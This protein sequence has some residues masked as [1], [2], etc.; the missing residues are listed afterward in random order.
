MGGC[1]PRIEVLVQIAICKSL[2]ILAVMFSRYH[3]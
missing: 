2:K 1:E 3:D